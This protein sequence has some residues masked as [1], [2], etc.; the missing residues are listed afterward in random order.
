MCIETFSWEHCVVEVLELF[1]GIPCSQVCSRSP[2]L[3]QVLHTH[4]QCF[5]ASEQLPVFV[6]SPCVCI[7]CVEGV[8]SALWFV[9]AASSSASS[10]PSEGQVG[11]YTNK[12]RCYTWSQR[13]G[14]AVEAG[15]LTKVGEIDFV[16]M[17]LWYSVIQ[18][19]PGR[20][21]RDCNEPL[22]FHGAG[23]SVL[24]S[25]EVRGRAGQQ[26]KHASTAEM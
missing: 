12:N 8:F 26:R 19:W 25:P 4:H 21:G 13:K 14:T 2:E 6:T 9:Y 24:A 20:W 1:T 3:A 17:F 5:M 22:L 23:W 18:Q 15:C 7:C 16:Q 10:K 11:S